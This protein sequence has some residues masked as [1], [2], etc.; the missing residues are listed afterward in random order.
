VCGAVAVVA[1][2]GSVKCLK[3]YFKMR[4]LNVKLVMLPSWQ[5]SPGN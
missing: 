1:G 2:D 4:F 3:K 5:D